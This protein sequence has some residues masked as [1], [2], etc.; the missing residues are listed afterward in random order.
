ML[1]NNPQIFFSLKFYY[2]FDKL[3]TY[4]RSSS[5]LICV[6]VGLIKIVHSQEHQST[7]NLKT[8]KKD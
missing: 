1:S 7:A 3:L 2:L 6:V 5:F 8:L 4:Y